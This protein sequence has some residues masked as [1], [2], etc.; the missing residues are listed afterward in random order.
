MGKS[1]KRT[2]NVIVKTQFNINGSR[3]K[4][5]GKFISDYVTR[6]HAADVSSAYIPPY[7]QPPVPGDGVA[8]TLDQSAISR[9]ETLDIAT[10]VQTLHAEGN[11]AIEQL[12]ISFSPDY[13]I[14][15]NLVPK[16]IAIHA[17]G[18]YQYNYDDVRM[19]HAV[20]VGIAA[21]IEQE[22]YYDG[23]MV[24]SIQSDT[25]HLHV[26]A[27]IYENGETIGRMRGEEERGVLRQSS[28]NRLI[29][30]IDQTLAETKVMDIVPTHRLL[31]PEYLPQATMYTSPNITEADVS[32]VNRYLQL[33]QEQERERLLRKEVDIDEIAEEIIA[34]NEQKNFDI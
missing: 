15:Q 29:Y 18:A 12:V 5:A 2:K 26:H 33:L 9:Q 30:H 19:R 14:E 23:N 22:G 11:R 13:L 21:M 17:K 25:L 27:V 34:E 4:D 3:G 8:F 10:H 32:F 31:T 16:D 7:N 28:L 1:P 24:A 6:E 20:R